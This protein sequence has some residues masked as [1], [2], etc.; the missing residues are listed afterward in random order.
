VARLRYARA[1]IDEGALTAAGAVLREVAA[2]TDGDP[3]E[4]AEARALLGRETGRTEVTP[5]EVRRSAASVQD[6]LDRARRTETER[7]LERVFGADAYVSLDTYAKGLHRAR[8]VARI[9]I[10]ARGRGFGTGFLVWG[11]DLA[12]RFGDQWVLL[13]SAHVISTK[14]EYVPVVQPDDAVITFEAL[15][16]GPGGTISTYGV[17]SVLWE[18]GPSELDVA[19]IELEKPVDGLGAEDRCA[20]ATSLPPNDQRGR[21]YLIGH[22][23]GAGLSYSIQDNPLLDYESP[24]LHYRAPT[25]GGSSGSP[26]YNPQWKLIGLH[27]AGFH[28]M[29]RLRGQPGTYEANEGIWIQAIRQAV[30]A[31]A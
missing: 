30:A 2:M 19:I 28:E 7:V 9:G 16:L 14:A 4:Q 31:S 6:A 21:V 15:P 23:G 26:I 13:T 24:R 3:T 8:T 20:V 12:D 11:R 25:E 17:R 1:L 5:A 22:P 27:H 29:P 18:S 10:E